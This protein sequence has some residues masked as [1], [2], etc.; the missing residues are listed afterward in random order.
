MWS[1]SEI[2]E[3]G[4]AAL[5]VN[6]WKCVLVSFIMGFVLSGPS[7]FTTRV[8]NNSEQSQQAMQ[9]LGDAYNSLTPAEQIAVIAGVSGVVTLAMVIGILV[10][11]FVY[12][13]LKVGGLAFFKK[14]VMDAPADLNEIGVGFKN[15][16]HTFVTLFLNDLFLTLWTMLL[17]VPGIIKSYSYRMVPYIIAD[18]PDLSPT[19]TITR[20]RQM[21]DGHKWHTFCYDLSFIGWVLLTILTCGLVGM[22]WFG[23]YKNNSDA[24]L[25]L[26]LRDGGMEPQYPEYPQYPQQP[27]QPQE[28]EQAVQPEEPQ[29]PEQPV[30][31]QEPEQPVQPQEPEAPVQP[32]EPQEP[33]QAVQPEEPQQ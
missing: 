18:E 3:R 13:P 25:Y 17:I 15:F 30:Q 5:K 6:Y 4:K 23:P 11:I 16:L 24:A 19:E 2:K 28:P 12:N 14:N 32:E 7:S 21:M 10:K 8:S 22:F 9:E 33:E 1:T 20:S 27:V 26:E 29:Q 31:P